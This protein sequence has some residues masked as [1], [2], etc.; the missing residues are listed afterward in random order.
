MF[1]SAAARSFDLNIISL[2]PSTQASVSESHGDWKGLSWYFTGQA[3]TGTLS[4]DEYRELSV[5]SGLGQRTGM[6]DGSGSTQWGYDSRGRLVRESKTV[7]G[8]GG[9]TFVILWSYNEAN[10]VES[11]SYPGGNDSQVGESVRYSYNA[12]MEMKNVLSDMGTPGTSGDDYWYMLASGY[13][14]AGRVVQRWLGGVYQA[15]TPVLVQGYSYTA[16]SASVQGGKLGRLMAGTYAAPGSLLN[17]AYTYDPGGNISQVVDSVANETLDYSYDE[18][19]RLTWSWDPNKRLSDQWYV[20][21]YHYDSAGRIDVKSSPGVNYAY[22]ATRQGM[23]SAGTAAGIL[24]AASQY[25][26]WTY[27]YDCN[28][29][30]TQRQGQALSYD[31]ENRLRQ[32]GSSASYVYD[33]DGQRVKGVENGTTT[34]YIGVGYE[35]SSGTAAGSTRY[36]YA[37]GVRIAMRRAGY[38]LNNGLFFLLSD[39]LG[40][41][42]KVIR[43]D[44]TQQEATGYQPW[45]E[46]KGTAL[47]LTIFTYTGQRMSSTGLLYLNAR[48]YDSALSLFTQADTLVPEPLFPLDW[49]RYLYARANPMRFTDPSGHEACDEDGF[50]YDH[51]KMVSSPTPKLTDKGKEIRDLFHQ[52]LEKNIPLWKDTTYPKG[53]NLIFQ[54]SP[55]SKYVIYAEYVDPKGIYLLDR[56]GK[57]REDLVKLKKLN[58][59]YTVE[60]IR[61]SNDANAIAFI[62]EEAGDAGVIKI[63][64]VYDMLAK[65]SIYQC[66]LPKVDRD[67]TAKVFWSP[68]N[69]SLVLSYRFLLPL[70]VFNLNTGVSRKLLD[71]AIV[72]GW[73]PYYPFP[74]FSK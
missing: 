45:G 18:M 33:G 70:Y 25:R 35:W 15:Q 6:T 14:A 34:I 27:Q 38:A 28:G 47:A 12:Q 69:E 46:L 51:G 1:Y 49:N 54:W 24:H 42:R 13:D 50:C 44:G 62:T 48:W 61:W 29:S 72:Y 43:E 63:V 60:D 19:N 65:T 37:G 17:L 11:Q 66:D 73:S 59:I 4:L 52:F 31:A 55:D 9:G 53:G 3:H 30:L 2:N 7:S 57:S 22:Q 71:Q 23:C 67:A 39:H 32:V 74:D 68:N 64:H 8:A 36:Y 20:N 21:N 41:T 26:A 40:S 16:W 5:R 56:D 58:T 10:Q